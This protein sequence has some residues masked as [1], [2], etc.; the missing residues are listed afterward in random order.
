MKVL[1]FFF[2]ALII[3]FGIQMVGCFLHMGWD[4]YSDYKAM[5]TKLEATK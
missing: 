5:I 2:T 4:T 3:V 1:G